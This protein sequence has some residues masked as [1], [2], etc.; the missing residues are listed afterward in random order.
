M[1]IFNDETQNYPFCRLQLKVET[2]GHSTEWTNQSMKRKTL[3]DFGDQAY[4]QLNVPLLPEFY[5]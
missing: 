1:D 2:F 3:S 5:K 4:K